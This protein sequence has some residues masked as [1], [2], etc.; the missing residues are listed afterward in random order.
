MR[1]EVR[2]QR[3]EV[4][5]QKSESRGQKSEVGGRRSD[6]KN[7]VKLICVQNSETDSSLDFAKDCR[8]I[9]GEQH[10]EL[11]CLCR[12]IGKMVG[13]MIKNPNAFLNPD[14]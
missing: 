2:E 3:S 11:T 4:G 12:E 14:L 5:D 13:S 8:Y 10:H 7:L 9:S 1:S 6:E